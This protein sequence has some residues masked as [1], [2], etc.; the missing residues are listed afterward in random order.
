MSFWA[1]LGF[2]AA[3]F[4]ALVAILYWLLYKPV[5]KTM[6]QREQQ[7][8]DRYGEAEG[9]IKDAEDARAKAEAKEHE[10]DAQRTQLLDEAKR[11]AE[12]RGEMAEA[13]EEYAAFMDERA[14]HA[15]ETIPVFASVFLC[16]LAGAVLVEDTFR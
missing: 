2:Q 3:N 11:D 14:E 16:V 13:L 9:K 8:Q 4:F 15:G 1:T 5:R 6:Q 7:I 12:Q 10:I